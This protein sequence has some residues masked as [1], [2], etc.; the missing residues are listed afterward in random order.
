MGLAAFERSMGC[1]SER[2]GDTQDAVPIRR[3]RR[4]LERATGIKKPEKRNNPQVN[5]VPVFMSEVE[6]CPHD[7]MS[8][9]APRIVTPKF[10]R[11]TLLIP[12]SIL[13]IRI[14]LNS[15]KNSYN[16]QGISRMTSML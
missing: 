7:D 12:L 9:L 3:T 4:E 15:L 10:S 11:S 16:R 13:E 6:P 5:L 1:I 2:A 14:Q 8:A